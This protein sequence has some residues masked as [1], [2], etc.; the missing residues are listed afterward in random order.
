M[1]ALFFPFSLLVWV[2]LARAT[3]AQAPG[4]SVMASGVEVISGEL[5]DPFLAKVKGRLG[6][7]E[8]AKA[9]KEVL[10]VLVGDVDIRAA[11][12]AAP[13][14]RPT[15]ARKV[16]EKLIAGLAGELAGTD[17]KASAE[18]L[19]EIALER[20]REMRTSH[21]HS[22]IICWCPKENWTLTL[23]GC[24][25]ECANGQKGLVRQWMDD[26][27]TDEEIIAKM[28][29]H[30]LGGPKVRALPV[31]EGANLIGYAFPFALLVLAVF[32]VGWFLRLI[33]RGGKER[34]SPGSPGSG[35]QG[36]RDQALGDQIEKELEEMEN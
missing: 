35:T 34:A 12:L 23:T 28:V 7:L 14:S 1:K 22:S 5:V 17:A 9:Y 10:R 24:A 30:P 26:G 16:R 25:R 36:V 15:M 18:R 31:A 33:T 19:V 3:V 29:A 6:L 27:Y 21:L 20:N 2:F 11:A 32:L 13:A 8:S 4:D